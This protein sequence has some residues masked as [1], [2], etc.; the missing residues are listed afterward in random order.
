MAS[1]S[2]L[3]IP[4]LEQVVLEKLFAPLEQLPSEDVEAD[5]RSQLVKVSA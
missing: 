1:V 2:F 5:E 3:Q 4:E